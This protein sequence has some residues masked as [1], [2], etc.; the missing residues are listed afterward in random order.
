MVAVV[1]V[2]PVVV[3]AVVMVMTVVMV[4]PAA[5]PVAIA[6]AQRGEQAG[7]ERDFRYSHRVS[8]RY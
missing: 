8:P 5:R 2:M 1:T 6:A 3:I 7:G 4:A